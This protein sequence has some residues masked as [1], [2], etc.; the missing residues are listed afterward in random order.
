MH[1]DLAAV[2]G[3]WREITFVISKLARRFRFRRKEGDEMPARLDAEHVVRFRE[4][5]RETASGLPVPVMTAGKTTAG[6]GQAAAGLADAEPGPLEY[7]TLR[8]ALEHVVREAGW[9]R[10]SRSP[11]TKFELELR[12]A[13]FWRRSPLTTRRAGRRPELYRS[14]DPPGP[15]TDG[16]RPAAPI[17]EPTAQRLI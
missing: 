10:A 2:L 17:P 6:G 15:A 8:Q 7:F 3:D 14:L 11:G 13:G 16:L 12:V 5:P 1:N 9:R 4:P